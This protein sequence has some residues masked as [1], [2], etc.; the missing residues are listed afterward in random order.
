MLLFISLCSPVFL[1]FMFN[2]SYPVAFHSSYNIGSFIRLYRSSICPFFKFA[3]FV[4]FRKNI[5][6]DIFLSKTL[7][8]FLTISLV[9]GA[10]HAYLVFFIR[11]TLYN[12]FIIQILCI[13]QLFLAFLKVITIWTEL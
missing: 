10:L 4:Y 11:N 8:L 5:F 7:D 12:K 2:L 1:P 9:S 3:F 6:L 13:K